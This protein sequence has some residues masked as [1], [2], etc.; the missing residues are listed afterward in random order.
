[1]R[2]FI[3]WLWIAILVGCVLYTGYGFVCWGGVC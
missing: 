2:D 1:M 3:I